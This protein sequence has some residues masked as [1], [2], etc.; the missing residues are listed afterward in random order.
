MSWINSSAK[1]KVKCSWNK[2]ESEK[3][4]LLSRFGIC[5]AMSFGRGVSAQLLSRLHRPACDTGW[6]VTFWAHGP[7]CEWRATP[8][9]VW[10][11]GTGSQV[12]FLVTSVCL[13]APVFIVQSLPVLLICGSQSGGSTPA[14]RPTGGARVLGPG[15]GEAPG[16]SGGRGGGEE[17]HLLYD[18]RRPSKLGSSYTLFNPSTGRKHHSKPDALPPSEAGLFPHQFCVWVWRSAFSDSAEVFSGSRGVRS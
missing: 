12:S 17:H 2:N 5:L 9:S 18:E 7:G 10:D 8:D 16:G 6:A 13:V 15:V 11:L 4:E 1:Q 14:L 3:E